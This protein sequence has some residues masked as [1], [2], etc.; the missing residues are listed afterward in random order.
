MAES[1]ERKYYPLDEVLPSDPFIL[2]SAVNMRLRDNHDSLEALC[3]D[4]NVDPA[5]LTAKLAG[6]GFEYMPA[7]NQFR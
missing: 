2:V 4:L 6:A 7:I 1:A 5:E 3:R